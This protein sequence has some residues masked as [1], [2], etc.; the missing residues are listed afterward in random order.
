MDTIGALTA[1]YA[2][3]ASEAASELRANVSES[4]EGIGVA[5]GDAASGHDVADVVAKRSRAFASRFSERVERAERA[6]DAASVALRGDV[7]G[8]VARADAN[9]TSEIPALER[10]LD[11]ALEDALEA[12]RRREASAKVAPRIRADA[13]E[14]AAE[15]RL[16]MEKKY[17]ARGN[18]L[19]DGRRA[20]ETRRAIRAAGEKGLA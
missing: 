17:L 18:H 16:R 19:G 13:L 10:A 12:L 4:L 20:R 5:T 8:A 7:L 15:K 1:A 6:L 9:A 2:N 14:A 3:A 11:A